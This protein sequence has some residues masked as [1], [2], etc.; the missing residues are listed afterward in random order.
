MTHGWPGSA[1][2]L[3]KVISPLAMRLGRRACHALGEARDLIF[4]HYAP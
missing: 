2:E 1:F 4:T 3:L